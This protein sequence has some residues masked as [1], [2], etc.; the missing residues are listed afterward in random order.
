MLLSISVFVGC[1]EKYNL[2]GYKN[3]KLYEYYTSSEIIDVLEARD[4]WDYGLTSELKGFEGTNFGYR[5]YV[6]DDKVIHGDKKIVIVL[7]QTISQKLGE[8]WEQKET[9]NKDWDK[10]EKE[11]YKDSQNNVRYTVRDDKLKVIAKGCTNLEVI[12]GEYCVN[13]GFNADQGGAS[14]KSTDINDLFTCFQ[15]AVK[16]Y[17]NHIKYDSGK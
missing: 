9:I 13:N 11:E 5:L 8:D 4:V 12:D 1:G 2:G 15:E 10:W 6:S 17:N 7:T 3:L 14:Y 16:R